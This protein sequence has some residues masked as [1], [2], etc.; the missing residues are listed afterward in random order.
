MSAF[1]HAAVAM[2]LLDPASRRLR[3]NAA[4]A[5]LFG[6]SEAELRAPGLTLTH[7]DDVAGDLAERARCLRGE[8]ASYRREKRYLH[9]DGHLIW[10]DHTGTLVRA[11]DGAPLHFVCQVHDITERKC[12]E[13]AL[14]ASEAR[15]R[16]L[17]MLSSDWYWEL[18]TQLRFTSFEGGHQSPNWRPNREVLLGRAR[19]EVGWLHPVDATWAEH[20]ALLDARQPFRE[21][22]FVSV[23]FPQQPVYLS[24]SGDPVFDEQGQFAGYRGTTRDITAAALA[25]QKLRSTQALLRMAARMGR[26]GAW[27]YR[28]DDE[29]VTW[30]EQL[31]AMQEAAPGFAPT[32]REVM[33]F[34][35][36]EFHDLVTAT[37]EGCL[38]AGIPFDI[39]ARARTLTGREVWLRVIGEARRDGDG[40][41]R[42]IEGACQ[43]ITASR[44][45]A[46]RSRRMAS[47]LTNTLERLTEGFFTLDREWRFTYINPAGALV[48]R[49][50]RGDLIGQRITDEFHGGAAAAFN[51]L[52]QQAQEQNVVVQA[53]EYYA[54]LDLWVQ[55]KI[56]PSRQGLAVYLRDVTERV[57]AQR[58]L[59][60][61]NA[62]LEERVRE[63]TAQLEIANRELE[64]FSYAIAHDLRAP[65]AA[66]RGFG[67]CLERS[68]DTGLDKLSRHYIAR[69]LHGVGHMTE[70]TGGLLS[71]AN[72]S[73]AGLRR[74]PVD[75]AEFARSA[76][77][78]CRDQSPARQADIEIADTLPAHGDSRLLVQLMENLVGNAWKFTGRVERARIEVGALPG[79]EG[80][81]T[82]FVRDNGAGFDPDYAGKLFEPF[83]RLHSREEFEG[84]GIGL[85]IVHKVVSLHGGRVWAD[86]RPGA[87]ASFYFTLG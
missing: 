5:R 52:Y 46:G 32:P 54:P 12:A 68:A 21:F 8:Q 13:A 18:D 41:V 55:L 51:R 59:L 29:R 69:I 24:S 16:S 2:V 70:L 83:Q 79:T 87:G 26:L 47:Q 65:L 84:T 57:L 50:P 9:R 23:R 31:C 25:E 20:R 10:A 73:R 85:A 44:K 33:G 75:L 1:K 86:S 74:T 43:D 63:R 30:S 60:R 7:P 27:A 40:N 82:Y 6:Y 45:A 37:F 38:R 72:L 78:A 14:R 11:A 66:I 48:L 53:E 17:T 19:W 34:F 4:Y 71:L 28:V 76:L 58:E 62:E 15:F 80:T 49:R 61:L 36:P 22:K 35:A 77:R 39:E 64:A 3:A 67:E 42:R 81:V 56:Y